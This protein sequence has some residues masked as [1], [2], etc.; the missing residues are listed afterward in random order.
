MASSPNNSNQSLDS[1]LKDIG[2]PS[3]S[4]MSTEPAPSPSAPAA[5]DRYQ[6]ILAPGPLEGVQRGIGKAGAE[7]AV[8]AGRLAG[9]GIGLVSPSMQTSLG[10]MA[11]RVPGVKQLEQFADRPDEDPGETAGNVL[12]SFLVGPE[13]GAGVLEPRIASFLD[14]IHPL[15]RMTRTRGLGEY[16]ATHSRFVPTPMGRVAKVAA[17]AGA[18]AAR[19]A[20]GGA[21]ANPDDPVTGAEVG[22]V[23]GAVPGLLG[24]G[25]QSPTGKYLGGALARGAAGA[26]TGGALGYG[27]GGEHGAMSGAGTGLSLGLI[28]GAKHTAVSYH[29]PVGRWLQKFGK[30]MFDKSGRFLGWINPLT[31]GFVAGRIYSSGAPQQAYEN[32]S[33]P[34]ETAA[35]STEE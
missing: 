26:A 30:G 16:A 14:S 13:T 31:G 12:G 6:G 11:Q 2:A 18:L 15:A 32:Y 17:P 5:T 9:K 1:Y 22:A 29:S 7:A 4:G 10:A 8:G 34:G 3:V 25:M 23:S 24:R 28:H 19:G 27:L 20:V 21:I 33:A 35:T